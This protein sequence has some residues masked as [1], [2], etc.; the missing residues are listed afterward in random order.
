MAYN[1][2]EAEAST[3]EESMC[4]R[5]TTT[6]VSETVSDAL[7]AIGRSVTYEDKNSSSHCHCAPALN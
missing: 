3:T 2:D 6:P 5:L 1:G 7:I 4:G